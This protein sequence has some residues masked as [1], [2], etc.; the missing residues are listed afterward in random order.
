MAIDYEKPGVFYLGKEYDPGADALKDDLR[1]SAACGPSATR[2]AS[3]RG[4]IARS[5]H[6]SRV[7]PWSCAKVS[8]TPRKSDIAVGQVALV[9]TQWRKDAD[10]FP[11]SDA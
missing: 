8:V 2:R 5:R 6:R 1:S 7:T 4:W 9:W 11:V 10:G 3:S